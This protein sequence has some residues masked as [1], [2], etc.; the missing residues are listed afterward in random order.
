MPDHLYLVGAPLFDGRSVL[1]MLR[2]F[3]GASTRVAWRL[4]AVGRL[5]Q[6]R[7][8]DRFLRSD[9]AVQRVAQYILDNPVRRGL[10]VPAGE[11]RWSAVVDRISL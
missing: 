8:C 4:G 10:V 6:P 9:E 1:D 11:Y 2:R 5:W 7:W 3:Q